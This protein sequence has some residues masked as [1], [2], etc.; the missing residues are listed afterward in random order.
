MGMVKTHGLTDDLGAL[1]VF[2]VV[3]QAHLLH[4]VQHA[5][6]DGFQ[7]IAHI[8]QRASDNHRHRIVEI[9]T[10]HLVLNVDENH[11]G[12]AGTRGTARRGA[13]AVAAI[14]AKRKLGVLLVCHVLSR[15]VLLEGEPKAYPAAN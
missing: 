6:V 13:A 4:G 2:L 10:P 5:P 3:L 9:R 1:G 8:R 11:V 7:T 14:I 12:G 15:T